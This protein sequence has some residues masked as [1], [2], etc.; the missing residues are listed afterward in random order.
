M[1]TVSRKMHAPDN[2]HAVASGSPVTPPRVS[3]EARD[4]PARRVP[5]ASD[6]PAPL[7]PRRPL[8]PQGAEP[9]LYSLPAW[10]PP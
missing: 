8:G 2:G 9:G 4:S 3:A 1:Y 5:L 10:L 7:A 6:R